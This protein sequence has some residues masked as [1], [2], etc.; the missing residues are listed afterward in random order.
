MAAVLLGLLALLVL[1]LGGALL[2]VNSSAGEERIRNLVVEGANEALQGKLGWERLDVQGDRFVFRGLKLFDPE[3]KLVAEI[4]RVEVELAFRALLRKQLVISEATLF[5][6]RLY[7]VLDERGLN[8]SRAIASRNPST[9]DTSGGG[10]VFVQL[11]SLVLQEGHVDFVQQGEEADRRLQLDGLTARG[12]ATYATAGQ[13]IEANLELEGRTVHPVEGPLRTRVGVKLAGLNGGGD[14]RVELPGLV[15]DTHADLQGLASGHLTLR[16]LQ[17]TPTTARAFLPSYP[18]QT[19][20]GLTGEVEMQGPQV[21]FTLDGKA[22]SGTLRAQGAANLETMRSEGVTVTGRGLNLAELMDNAPSTQ[23]SLDLSARGGGTSLETLDGELTLEVPPSQVEGEPLGPI[24]LEASAKDGRFQVPKLS[25]VLPGVQLR[26]SGEGTLEQL[27]AR[28]TLQISDLTRLGKTLGRIGQAQPPEL[29][30]SGSLSFS[31]AGPARAPGV[32][33]DGGFPTLSYQ[34][35]SVRDLTLEAN[36]PDVTRPLDSEAT[37]GVS[38]LSAGDRVF[39]NLRVQVRSRAQEF[40]LELVTGGAI[41]LHLLA[42]GTRDPDSRGLSLNTLT[43]DYPEASWSLAQPARLGF[44]EEEIR[45]SGL[46]LR[47][48]QQLLAVDASLRGQRVE[49]EIQVE[50]FDLGRIPKI[51]VDPSFAL[52]GRVD[53]QLSARGTLR[54]PTA[55][56]TLE[57]TDGGFKDFRKLGLSLQGAYAKDRATGELSAQSEIANLRARFEVP[58]QGLLRRRTDPLLLTLDVEETQLQPA[59]KALGRP[60]TAQGRA[61]AQLVL[62]GSAREPLVALH[63]WGREVRI[64]DY[65]PRPLENADFDLRMQSAPEDRLNAQIDLAS[66]GVSGRIDLRTPLTLAEVMARPPTPGQLLTTPVELD[67][68][69][70]RVPLRLLAAAGAPQLGGYAQVRAEVRGTAQAPTVNAQVEV[71]QAGMRG[72]LP[73]DGSL[74]LVADDQRIELGMEVHREDR[75]LL[76]LVAAVS[77]PLARLIEGRALGEIPLQMKGVLHPL[78]LSELQPKPRDEEEQAKQASG[79]V[80]AR[81]DAAGTLDAPR[82]SLRSNLEEVRVGKA[83]IGRAELAYDYLDTRSDLNLDLVS[84]GDGTLQLKATTQIPLGY[85]ALQ[86]GVEYQNAKVT[87]DLTARKFELGSFSGLIP[88]VRAIAGL[89]EADAHIEGTVSKPV[90]RGEVEWKNGKLA[91]EGYGDFSEAH[92]LAHATNDRLHLEELKAKSGAGSLRVVLD[93]RRQGQSANFALQGKTELSRFPLV[94]DDQLMAILTTNMDLSGEASSSLINIRQLNIPEAHVELPEILGGKDLQDL[95]RPNDVIFVRN[96]RPLRRRRTPDAPPA[97]PEGPDAFA[98]TGTPTP[99]TAARALPVEPAAAPATPSTQVW[100]T[101]NAPR[102]LWVKGADINAELGLSE[103][104]R[105]EYENAAAVYGEVR[106]LRGEVDVLGRK[107]KVQ[108]QSQVRFT[109]PPKMPYLNLTAVHENEREEVTVFVTVRGQGKEIAQGLKVS[110]QPVLSETEIFTLLATGRRTLKRG[111]G[112]SM[113]TGDAASIV[114]AL[115]A[116]TL[117]RTLSNKL[118]LDVFT[119]ESTGE[120]VTGARIEAGTYITDKWYM[121]YTQRVGGAEEGENSYGVKVEYQVTP[122]ISVEGEYGDQRKGAD[123]IWSR[124]Y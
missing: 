47:S 124:D 21:K 33:L 75:K 50:Q 99:A 82:L 79:V 53:L 22:A 93:A 37:L 106:F 67:I 76:E 104:F 65:P 51:A 94:V 98:P 31:V 100:V 12:D 110:S 74:T 14:L 71:H 48:D 120:G 8:L 111:S 24:H 114:G 62:T 119:I 26:A 105:V 45:I 89:L 68:A 108:R 27:T 17:L 20:V 117:K 15:L 59:L 63:L 2:Y 35:Y 54:S 73:L 49:A 116:T 25:A 84:L 90:V 101:I 11:D 95:D 64:N 42:V 88:K 92:L 16:E 83:C 85:S 69:L 115:A 55:E 56:G 61:G 10:E 72:A 107:F 81:W 32:K 66:L 19:P 122:S 13:R 52:S 121:G 60:E 30:G 86:R 102:N 57:L 23:L 113:N 78:A 7:L 80:L 109:G 3:G 58:V 87:A 44:R 103:G 5:R 6:P 18:V 40:R 70:L 36:V 39:R 9:G 34:T 118:P 91:L 97:A 77:A 38:Y 41:D 123:L 96:G 1:L 43:L 4:E 46:Q 28:G 112:S 29:S